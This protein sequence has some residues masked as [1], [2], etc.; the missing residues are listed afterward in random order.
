[1]QAVGGAGRRH[2]PSRLQ[3]TLQG[4]NASSVFPQRQKTSRRGRERDGVVGQVGV[5]GEAF[6]AGP[7]DDADRLLAENRGVAAPFDLRQERTDICATRRERGAIEGEAFR[8]DP[9]PVEFRREEG[10]PRCRVRDL[11]RQ[12]GIGEFGKAREFLA[13]PLAHGFRQLALEVAE[14]RKRLVRPPL[15]AH[16]QHRRLR[17]EEIDAGERPKGRGGGERAQALAERPVADM[18][19]VLQEDDECAGRK[20]RARP[21]ARRAAM[22]RDL[23]LKG[24]SLR[25]RPR[26]QLRLAIVAV[27]AAPLA[28]RRDVQH[29]VRIVVPLR[30]V[31]DGPA[32]AA[33][34][35]LRFVVLV[36]EQEMDRPS[37]ARSQPRREFVDDVRLAV[38]LDRVRRVQAEAIEAKNFDP[39]LGVLDHEVTNR[40]RACAVEIDRV[41]PGRAVAIGEEVR[42]VGA[43]VIPLWSEMIV[44][45]VEEHG[46]S[47]LVRRFDEALE[48]LRAA[49]ARIGR[50]G[51]DPII[52][53]SPAA[54]KIGDRHDFDRSDAEFGEM[55]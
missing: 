47:A 28:C 4:P 55:V 25:Q 51:I 37:E 40:P 13:A 31:E 38:I 24:E 17:Q 2:G 35:T 8:V 23:A 36:L 5:E 11:R 54:A 15:L 20:S 30:C 44:D 12:S 32:L 42:S 10:L 16:E 43:E 29:M 39:V 21:P 1:M 49:V 53:P 18:I 14:E 26:E 9:V 22:G 33:D 27:I 45:H 52:A 41:A 6:A 7:P 50:I 34:E 48:V 3:R 19:M 46:D